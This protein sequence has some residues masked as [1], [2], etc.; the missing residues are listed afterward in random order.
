[1]Y[2]AQFYNKCKTGPVLA[3]GDRAIIILDGRLAHKVN[4]KLAAQVA[5]ERGYCGY[6]IHK[7]ETFNRGVT[8]LTPYQSV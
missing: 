1:M 5:R 6:S 4:N 3:C 7:G 2:F 8:T